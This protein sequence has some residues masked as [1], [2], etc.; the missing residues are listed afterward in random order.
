MTIPVSLPD[1]STIDLAV[2]AKLDT[3][4]KYP[5]HVLKPKTL[6]YDTP[7]GQ[8][9]LTVDADYLPPPSPPA[10]PQPLGPAG[11]WVLDT[12]RT[13]EFNEGELDLTRWAYHGG[14]GVSQ[15]VNSLELACYDSVCVDVVG[16]GVD[17]LNLNLMADEE[18]LATN[19]GEVTYQQVTGCI[20]SVWD[21]QVGS[22]IEVAAVLPATASGEV[23]NSTGTVDR[24]SRVRCVLGAVGDHGLLRRQ[25]RLG[26][27]GQRSDHADDCDSGQPRRCSQRG[28]GNNGC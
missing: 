17:G 25:A 9:T 15:P 22:F 20:K 2:T 3:S 19:W 7:S 24:P 27:L 26:R 10:S 14:A 21:L 28:P 23:A 6:V 4:K 8:A 1:G 12:T 13:S 11:Q 16:D 5:G 18:T